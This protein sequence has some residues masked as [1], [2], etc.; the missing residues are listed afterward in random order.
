MIRCDL[1]EKERTIT[2]PGKTDLLFIQENSEKIEKRLEMEDIIEEGSSCSLLAS[3]G[4]R[5]HVGDQ[6]LNQVYTLYMEEGELQAT[7]C[8]GPE[9]WAEV[10]SIAGMIDGGLL[11][12]DAITQRILRLS[13]T[14]EL[15]GHA[16]VE[17]ELLEA[18]AIAAW[19]ERLVIAS[20][21]TLAMYRME[22]L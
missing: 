10:S 7:V 18:V 4:G 2:E 3:S 1:D 13:A 19:G 11:V 17:G 8:G 22:E 9:Q 14:G 21:G 16:E 20:N 12:L 6:G 15:M 5:Y